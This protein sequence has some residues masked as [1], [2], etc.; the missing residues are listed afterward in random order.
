MTNPSACLASR[1]EATPCSRRAFVLWVDFQDGDLQT[2]RT[3]LH[4][5]HIQSL[6]AHS[7]DEALGVLQRH[8]IAIVFVNAIHREGEASQV[9][10]SIRG[11]PSG[12]FVPLIFV[13]GRPGLTLPP[14]EGIE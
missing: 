1:P 4:D 2:L 7:A 9:A 14:F 6:E 5:Q 13:A 11:T 8:D 10:E 12:R 3:W